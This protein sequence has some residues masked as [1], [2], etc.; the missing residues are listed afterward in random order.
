MSQAF[1]RGIWS[2]WVESDVVHPGEEGV[3]DEVGVDEL[4]RRCCRLLR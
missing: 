2:E 4:W 1:S 3:R